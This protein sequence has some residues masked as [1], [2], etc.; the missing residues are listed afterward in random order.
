MPINHFKRR[1]L[2]SLVAVGMSLSP[3][4]VAQTAPKGQPVAKEV[5]YHTFFRHLVYL[6]QQSSKSL[7]A[8]RST[9]AQ[10]LRNYYQNRLHFTAQQ[11]SLVRRLAN[12][13]QQQVNALD[14]QAAPI[15][16]AFRTT[17]ASAHAS[18]TGAPTVPPE[19]AQLQKRKTALLTSAAS[20]LKSALGPQAGNQLETFLRTQWA[21]H[22]TVSPIR[23]ARIHNPAVAPA[24]PF[25]QEVR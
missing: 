21:P 16:R 8:G 19:L 12:D 11:F 15:I 20:Q 7:G 6:D 2:G 25:N 14:A 13:T 22:V 23:A 17:L 1:A 9:E 18:G 24:P 10:D 5:L 3:L 4:L